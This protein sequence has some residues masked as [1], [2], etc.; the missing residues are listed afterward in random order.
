MKRALRTSWPAAA[1]VAA[2]AAGFALTALSAVR[3]PGELRQ[4][5]RRKADAWHLGKLREA[6]AAESAALRA[7]EPWRGG[8]EGDLGDALAAAVGEGRWELREKGATGLPGGWALRSVSATLADGGLEALGRLLAEAAR[9][10]PPWRLQQCSITAGESPGTG[11]ASL[12]LERIEPAAA[13]RDA[14]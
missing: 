8:P 7:F 11:R 6:H 10:R 5:A 2:C 1:A 13:G 12:E 9:Q 3:T 14:P 4:I